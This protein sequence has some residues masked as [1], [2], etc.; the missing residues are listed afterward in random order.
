VSADQFGPYPPIVSR[1]NAMNILNRESVLRIDNE[2]FAGEKIGFTMLG[3]DEPDRKD[4]DTTY[5][6]LPKALVC[7]EGMAGVW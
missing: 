3:P 5:R 1:T 7:S 4:D 6:T 2:T